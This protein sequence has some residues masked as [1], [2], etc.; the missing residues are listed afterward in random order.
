MPKKKK[1]NKTNQKKSFQTIKVEAGRGLNVSYNITRNNKEQKQ[2][3]G[4]IC[5][6]RAKNSGNLEIKKNKKLAMNTISKTYQEVRE[7]DKES[8][9][10]T[11]AEKIVDNISI[12]GY[13]HIRMQDTVPSAIVNV[14]QIDLLLK[15]IDNQQNQIVPGNQKTQETGEA[16]DIHKKHGSNSD[17]ASGTDS[18]DIKNDG[19]ITV[20]DD[21]N[22]TENKMMH[23]NGALGAVNIA[24][25]KNLR[26]KEVAENKENTRKS[27]FESCDTKTVGNIKTLRKTC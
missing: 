21:G 1:L 16:N 6:Q 27:E 11:N 9:T 19:K 5:K 7:N 10:I 13:D 2:A 23:G 3:P 12:P 20:N 18:G 25:N 15:K 8:N 26:Y 17:A 14:N 24:G 22:L 4:G